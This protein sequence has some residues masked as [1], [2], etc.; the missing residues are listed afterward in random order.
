[1]KPK[2]GGYGFISGKINP[3]GAVFTSFLM[4]FSVGLG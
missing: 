1:M 4:P 2:P 3:A